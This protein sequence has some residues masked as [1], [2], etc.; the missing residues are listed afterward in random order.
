MNSSRCLLCR[1]NEHG[2][3]VP[4]VH[5]PVF[6]R[7]VGDAFRIEADWSVQPPHAELDGIAQQIRSA[8]RALAR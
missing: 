8:Y 7:F 1:G 5:L 2:Q 3:E 6:P 4:H